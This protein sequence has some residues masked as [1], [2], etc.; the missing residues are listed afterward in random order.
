MN[1]SYGLYLLFA[2]ILT[3]FCSVMCV[4]E[5][6]LSMKFLFLV[7]AIGVFLLVAIGAMQ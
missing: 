7:S 4:S 2:G 6:K 1:P 5:M 3:V